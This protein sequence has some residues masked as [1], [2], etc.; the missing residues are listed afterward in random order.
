[1]ALD[2][3]LNYY[4][5]ILVTSVIVGKLSFHYWWIKCINGTKNGKNRIS[6]CLSSWADSWENYVLLTIWKFKNPHSGFKIKKSGNKKN[7]YCICHCDG[8]KINLLKNTH[9]CFRSLLDSTDDS[10][11]ALWILT[12][13]WTKS[14]SWNTQGTWTES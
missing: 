12:I 14:A 3:L 9:P 10:Q 5:W 2:F 4:C 13:L 8:I 7:C 6:S 1:M 11:P